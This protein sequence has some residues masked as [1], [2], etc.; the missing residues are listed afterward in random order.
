MQGVKTPVNDLFI[1]TLTN[2]IFLLTPQEV[3]R[4]EILTK[5][6]TNIK[7]KGNN[8]YVD[9][10]NIV[11]VGFVK[12]GFLPENTEKNIF[13]YMY[14]NNIPF[15]EIDPSVN[16]KP[17][18]RGTPVWQTDSYSIFDDLKEVIFGIAGNPKEK[19]AI[20]DKNWTTRYIVVVHDSPIDR[21]FRILGKTLNRKPSMEDAW[22][23]P[24]QWKGGK[25]ENIYNWTIAIPYGVDLVNGIFDEFRNPSNTVQMA[26]IIQQSK[27][28]S[29]NWRT[30]IFNRYDEG[31]A[32]NLS[33]TYRYRYGLIDYKKAD[34][35]RSRYFDYIRKHKK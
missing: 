35:I 5:T 16:A 25:G 24:E 22:E 1:S 31:M 11:T 4:D 8:T 7:I 19:R 27:K 17:I 28:D 14:L 12:G 10:N 21:V 18:N 6:L 9:K 3:F 2:D 34:G 13:E 26:L 23:Y 32:K 30:V 15:G 33:L 20:N 29:E